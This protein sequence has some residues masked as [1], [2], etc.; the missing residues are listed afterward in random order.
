MY[1]A[2]A[3]IRGKRVE[4][5]A[6]DTL[7]AILADTEEELALRPWLKNVAIEETHAK[8]FYINGKWSKAGLRHNVR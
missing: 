7:K 8:M 6:A 2:T 3:L 1:V 4:I 5:R